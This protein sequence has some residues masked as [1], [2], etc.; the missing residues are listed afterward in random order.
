LIQGRIKLF[1]AH[2]AQAGRVQ[3]EAELGHADFACFEW[4][5]V[6]RLVEAG[7]VDDACTLALLFRYSLLATRKAV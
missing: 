2:I 5:E 3:P 4:A 6:L 1:A 7:E